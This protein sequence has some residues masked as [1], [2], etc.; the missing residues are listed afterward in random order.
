[1]KLYI[2]EIGDRLR[3]TSAWT[4]NLHYERRNS[5]LLKFF[6]DEEYNWKLNVKPRPV[7]LKI[8]TLL[9]IDR[10]YIRKGSA[11]FS[12]LSFYVVTDAKKTSSFGKPVGLRFWAKLADCNNIEFAPEKAKPKVKL[13]CDV[14]QI[15]KGTM[16]FDVKYQQKHYAYTGYFYR[17]TTNAANIA[18]SREPV[19]KVDVAADI[20][21][22]KENADSLYA[23]MCVGYVD[24]PFYSLSTMQNEKIGQYT[25]FSGLKKA[26]K[27]WA[28]KNLA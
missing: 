12:S 7:K 13:L 24:I 6:F 18:E 23:N 9:Q 10:I 21:W 26:A 1:M 27:T 25:S 8:G 4:F 11:E 14:R 17:E 19:L 15:Q 5:D 22:K 16:T 2:P 28:E 20:V 3:L